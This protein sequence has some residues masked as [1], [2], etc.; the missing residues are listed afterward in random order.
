MDCHAINTTDVLTTLAYEHMSL[1][2]P[3]LYP[4]SHEIYFYSMLSNT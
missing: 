3:V 4:F 1:H 2:V